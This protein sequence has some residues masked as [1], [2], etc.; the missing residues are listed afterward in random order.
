M[1]GFLL[2]W[3]Q[4]EEILANRLFMF[5]SSGFLVGI[6]IGVLIEELSAIVVLP[7]ISIGLFIYTAVFI[8]MPKIFSNG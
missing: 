7:C 1:K 8:C 3:S 4:I 6:V 5:V 2:A